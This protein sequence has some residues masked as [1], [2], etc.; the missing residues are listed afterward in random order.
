MVA[1]KMPSPEHAEVWTH[2]QRIL[3]KTGGEPAFLIAVKE[4]D[5]GPVAIVVSTKQPLVSRG[6]VSDFLRMVADTLDRPESEDLPL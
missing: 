5:A 3:D 1:F 2:W 4:S 6:Y